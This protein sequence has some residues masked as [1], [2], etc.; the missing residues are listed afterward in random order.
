M[1]T[2]K[3]YV[4]LLACL[5]AIAGCS[6]STDPAAPQ[7]VIVISS[8]AANQHF[9]DGDTI[10]IRGN[11]THTIELAEVGVHMT[12]QVGN[13]E[14]FHNHYL[15]TGKTFF[16]FDATYKVPDNKKN[17]FNVEIEVTD[18]NNTEVKKELKITIN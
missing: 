4:W 5:P 8:P 16:E 10:H 7:P 11:V 13:N 15:T 18:K 14:F 6:K 17:T 2:I 3:W 9:A 12:E 1:R